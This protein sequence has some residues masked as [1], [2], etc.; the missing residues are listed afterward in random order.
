M[1]GK[2][3][4][5]NAVE[6]ADQEAVQKQNWDSFVNPFVEVLQ[7]CGSVF[8]FPIILFIS[9]IF[10][11]RSGVIAGVEKCLQLLKASCDCITEGG[12]L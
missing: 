1:A 8:L 6:L 10:G 11:F 12:K 4:A 3:V 9:I 7:L 2:S 5:I